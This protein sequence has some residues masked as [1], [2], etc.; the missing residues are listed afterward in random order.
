MTGAGRGLGRAH[1][2]TLAAEGA[3]VVVNDPGTG[4]DGAGADASPAQQVVAEIEQAGGRAVANLDSCADWNAAEM[5]VAQAVDTFGS[6]DVLVNNAGILRDKMSFN[7]A[8]ADWDAV[9]EVHLKGHF[10]PSRFAAAYWRAKA[11][12]GGDVYGR[13]VNTSSESGY[14]GLVGQ[15][16][17]ATA[18]AGIVGMTLGMARELERIGVTVN[19]IA[20]RAR[21]RMTTGAFSGYREAVE[22]QFDDRAPENISPVVA[23]LAGPWAGHI[24]GKVFVC[25]G[26]DVELQSPIQT[27]VH[28]SAGERAWT[29][30][31]LVTRSH[32]FF[33]GDSTPG[34]VALRAGIGG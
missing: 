4:G 19:A 31:E 24:S 20:P 17:Y 33:P 26:G 25:Y 18:K 29:V 7:M 15:V 2:L 30:E 1:A 13:I 21:T 32:E 34:V 6:L 9:M 23:W 27:A 12:E 28:L 22:G 16:N 10:A 11:K 14:I 8:E 5:L 3:A